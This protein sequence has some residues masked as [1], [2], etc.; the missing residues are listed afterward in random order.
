MASGSI[1]D[2]RA[3]ARW[4]AISLLAVVALAGC[5]GDDEGDSDSAAQDE[6]AVEGRLLEYAA[7]VDEEA[8]ARWSEEL[9]AREGGL[10]GCLRKI[11][12]EVSTT[13][14]IDDVTVDGD[15]AEVLLTVLP[16]DV[17]F[18]YPVVREGEPTDSFD[19]WR[20]AEVDLEEVTGEP[21]EST[22]ETTTAVATEETT[23]E[24]SPQ[25][26]EEKAAAYRACVE[27]RGAQDVKEDDF[28]SVDFSGGGSRVIAS[29]GDSEEDAE[30]G[31]ATIRQRDPFF[32]ERFGTLVLYSVGDPL[33]DDLDT[34]L[35]C[36]REIG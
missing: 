29:F 25:T 8:C 5:G 15:T 24:S 23:T 26:P 9:L 34:G 13:I 28:P 3:W 17:Q 4:I 35:G 33:A 32:A 18:I 27:D 11:E 12:R 2:G 7:G 30:Q 14:K 36:A 6:A 31:L 16:D 1:G 22:T 10:K 21:P 20:I 19:G